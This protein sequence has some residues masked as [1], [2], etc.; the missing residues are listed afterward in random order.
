MCEGWCGK[1]EREREIRWAPPRSTT[2]ALVALH[3]CKA[4]PWSPP[5]SL[6]SAPRL[7]FQ[8]PHPRHTPTPIQHSSEACRWTVHCASLGTPQICSARR[9]G[10]EKCLFASLLIFLPFKPFGTFCDSR[11]SQTM[12]L[13]FWKVCVKV[14]H[15]FWQFV[16]IFD[17][18]IPALETI[19]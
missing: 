6:C 14:L 5:P 10:N 9:Q 1:R 13:Q 18:C 16:S 7:P 12:Q 11:E 8:L 19:N 3:H 4:P 17:K 2:C 15:C